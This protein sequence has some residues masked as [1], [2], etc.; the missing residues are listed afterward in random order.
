VRELLAALGILWTGAVL[1]APGG[2]GGM[3]DGVRV[4]TIAQ[5]S[6]EHPRQSEGAMV[7]L[8][9][10]AVLLVWQEFLA[11]ELGG[12][13]NAP[14]R[15]ATMT[16]TDGGLTWGGHRV[17]VASAPGD[18]NVYSPNL[19]RLDTGEI[20]FIFMRYHSVYPCDTSGFVWVSHDEGQTFE[21]LAQAW[22]HQTYGLCSATLRQLP[23]GRLIIPMSR[24]AGTEGAAADHWLAGA[25]YSDDRGQTWHESA[26][27]VDL[28]R[29]GCMEPHIAWLRDGSLLMLMRT[30][31]GAL[32][33]TRSPDDGATWS[34]PEG[35]G[36][37]SPESCPELI[38]IP[39]TG[40]LLAVWNDGAYD[41]G[42]FSHFGKRTPLTVALSR[43]DGR[44]WAPRFGVEAD[45]GWAFSN[46]GCAFLSNGTAIVNYWA[47]AYEPSG[48]MG[49]DRIDLKA[50]IVD[51]RALYRA[52]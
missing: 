48:R 4:V 8:M 19:I 6:A 16:S 10:G 13:D 47:C 24:P 49:V 23:T 12:E 37:V 14:S 34:E 50:A 32:Y 27:W 31:L 18:V 9:G 11:S 26:S 22:D 38:N 15:L 36:M 25:I 41:P 39:G 29:R 35:T 42:W 52:P 2:D 43:D 46:P 17:V 1:A 51:L 28:A 5:A 21:P 7:E 20:L 33:A 40:D 3:A 44:T 45:P 30:Q